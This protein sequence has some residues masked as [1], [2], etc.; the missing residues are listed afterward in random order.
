VDYSDD[1]VELLVSK[2]MKRLTSTSKS[3]HPRERVTTFIEFNLITLVTLFP[4]SLQ[5]YRKR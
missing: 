5:R 3:R 4:T 2:V 1:L